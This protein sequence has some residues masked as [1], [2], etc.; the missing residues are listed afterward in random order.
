MAEQTKQELSVNEITVI[1]DKGYY[2]GN[3]LRSCEENGI[4]AIVS[5]Q[6]SSSKTGDDNFNKDKFVY[7]KEKDV[8]ICPMG[9]ILARRSGVNSKRQR[10]RSDE[11]NDCANRSKCT[12]NTKGREVSPTEYQE[13]YDR[14]DKLFAEN[15]NLYKHRQMIVEH[16][17]GTIKRALGYTYFL[18]R[19]HEDVKCESYMHF[20]IYN[21]K[22]V[23]NIMGDNS[24]Y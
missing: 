7:D 15:L 6:K 18:Q 1:A 23:I 9:K 14:A 16:P 24:A 11:C 19:G 12:T 8:Y 10:Y 22:R 17:F 13:Y 4:T 5:K 3:D 21:F 2:N 20:F